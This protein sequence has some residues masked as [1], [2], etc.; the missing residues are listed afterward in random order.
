MAQLTLGMTG[1][2]VEQTGF[3]ALPI[4]RISKAEAVKLLRRALDGGMTYFDTARAYSD[5]EE[6]LGAAFYGM[7]DKVV[8]ATKVKVTA[9]TTVEEFWDSLHTS[10][11]EL[12]IDCV[13]VLQFH[14]PPYC[15]RPGDKKGLYD[16]MLEARRQ[17]K[18]RHIGITCHRMD[19]AEE[20]VAS[21]LYEV[22]MYPFNY[23]STP[24]EIR[25]AEECAAKNIGFVAMKGLSGGLLGNAAAA[26]AW[27]AQHPHVLPIWGVQH[28]WELE[29]FLSFIPTP[30]AMTPE[31]EAVIAKDRAQL[32]GEFCRA[33]GYC[34][35]C[36]QGIE[37][38]TCARAV[39]LMRRSPAQELWTPEGEAKMEKITTCLECGQCSSRCPYG[40]DTPALLKKNYR[41]YREIIQRGHL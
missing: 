15:P 32:Q 4:Q 30:P 34:M 33:C 17:G 23:L 20:A 18:L 31:L 39:L 6:K 13:D 3:G 19:V 7:W 1:L 11:R 25:I 10:L 16:A 26:A 28:A 41:E 22:L 9:E 8:V 40:L 35:P 24:E 27:M 12:R 2:R 37:I 29:Q 5:S 14:M 38:N 21:G 36:P